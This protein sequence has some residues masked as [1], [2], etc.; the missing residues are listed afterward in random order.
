ML[1]GGWGEGGAGFSLGWLSSLDPSPVPLEDCASCSS[2]ALWLGCHSCLIGLLEWARP[3][4]KSQ[5]WENFEESYPEPDCLS[6]HCFYHVY[7]ASC[8]P[9]AAGPLAAMPGRPPQAFL[10]LCPCAPEKH[11]GLFGWCVGVIIPLGFSFHFI[12][13]SV[14]HAGGA[15][16]A[17]L[18]QDLAL[19]CV[20][21]SANLGPLSGLLGPW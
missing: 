15:R 9:Q 2:R 14:P 1:R 21:L 10:S 17:G 6:C 16:L 18:L 7:C 12:L 19:T 4:L 13:T 11:R 8:S 5:G 3:L 20:G